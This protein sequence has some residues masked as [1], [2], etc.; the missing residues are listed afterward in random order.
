MDQEPGP[1]FQEG[2]QRSLSLGL[3]RNPRHRSNI[4]DQP[5]CTVD[6][7]LA[8]RL[9]RCRGSGLLLEHQGSRILQPG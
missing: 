6:M 8:I 2:G 4:S 9:D 5:L 7:V 3:D 1:R